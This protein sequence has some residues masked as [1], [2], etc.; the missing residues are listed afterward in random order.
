MKKI[1]LTLA[2]VAAVLVGAVYL[3]IP[4]NNSI[5][6]TKE[7]TGK[8]GTL[9]RI[10]F[11]SEERGKWLPKEGKKIAADKYELDGC[12]FQFPAPHTQNNNLQISRDS[13]VVNCTVTSVP[14]KENVVS[15]WAVSNVAATGFMDRIRTYFE[16]RRMKSAMEKIQDGIGGLMTNDK[17]IYGFNVRLSQQTDST[18][19]SIKT[20]TTYP[21]GYGEIYGKIK[22]LS[23]YASKAG[24]AATNSPMLNLNKVSASTWSYMVALPINKEL[25]NKG[26][27]LAKRMFSGGKIL[28]TDS[29]IGG[30]TK[31]EEAIIQLEKYR[32]DGNFMSPAIPFQSMITN[33]SL[34]KDS[35]RWITKLYYPVY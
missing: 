20:E 12:V 9:R 17:L 2:I 1:L 6:V 29:I 31:I 18:L 15:T 28:I 22:A 33:R 14:D 27:I 30:N 3:F 7:M 26:E 23:A 21:P 34:E 25:G 35:S 11:E 4:K 5:F 8:E 32:I 24:A 13:F 16:L 10:I 19:V